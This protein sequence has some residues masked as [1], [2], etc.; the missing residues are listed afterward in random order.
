MDDVD[1]EKAV[2]VAPSVRHAP[3]PDLYDHGPTHR[4]RQ[5]RS[6]LFCAARRARESP[7]RGRPQ[8][9]AP[10]HWTTHRR[11]TARPV[12]AMVSDTV[13]AGR[14]CWRENLRGSVLPSHGT[15]QCSTSARLTAKRCSVQWLRSFLFV[16]R[17]SRWL[18]AS[19]SHYDSRSASCPTT[20]TRTRTGQPHSLGSD[21][22]QR[23]DRRDEAVIPFG[24]RT[25]G[26]RIAD[27]RFGQL[28]AYTETQWV[29]AQS[30][31]R[32]TPSRNCSGQRNYEPARSRPRGVDRLA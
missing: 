7:S 22:H 15:H 20:T 30:E 21:S 25:L 10:W 3:G 2:S 8:R 14:R 11:E 5:N 23:P 1:L 9:V 24:A 29:T 17:R 26:Q 6:R 12:H 31:L 4:R 28:D 19:A 13:A 16:A 27:G 18:L 32:R